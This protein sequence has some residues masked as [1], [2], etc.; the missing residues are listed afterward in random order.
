[1]TPRLYLALGISGSMHHIGGI[2]DSRRLVAVN[3][4]AK[5]PIFPNTDEG[6]V[7]DLNEVLPK[8]VDR[9][10]SKVGGTQ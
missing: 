4:D 1:V 8:L 9:V 10:R 2:K 5:A 6:F 7:A 3:I